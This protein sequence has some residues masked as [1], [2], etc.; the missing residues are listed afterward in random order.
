MVRNGLNV[1]V[2][3]LNYIIDI[4]G[5]VIQHSVFDFSNLIIFLFLFFFFYRERNSGKRK[6]SMLY[7]F[8]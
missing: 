6:V 7:C 1:D 4:V 8:K 2:H 3:I 5:I